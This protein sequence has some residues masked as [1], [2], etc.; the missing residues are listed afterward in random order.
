[1]VYNTQKEAEEALK[2][3][4]TFEELQEKFLD[5][6]P[7]C[8]LPGD[9]DAAVTSAANEA[10]IKRWLELRKQKQRRTNNA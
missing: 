10:I 1:M 4:E 2:N 9:S 5:P 3:I 8:V 7:S 6:E